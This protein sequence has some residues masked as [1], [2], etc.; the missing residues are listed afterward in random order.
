[1]V[2]GLPVHSIDTNA[3]ATWGE[4]LAVEPIDDT[5]AHTAPHRHSFTQLVLIEAGTGSHLIDF[6]RVPLAAGDLH[7]L[8]PGQVHA[9]EAGPGLAATAAMFSDGALDPIGPFPDPLRE[10]VLFGA[11]PIPTDGA[12][13]RRIRAILAAIA[14]TG[15]IE[16]GRHLTFGLLWE[17]LHALGD[18]VGTGSDFA[19][20]PLT[21]RF[22]RIAMR[23]PNAERTVSACAAELGVT[24]GHLTEHIS[25]SVG[26]T[27]GELLRTALTREA[28]RHLSGT[29]LSVAQISALLGFSTPSYFS[30]FFRR[31]AGCSPREYRH[32]PPSARPGF[33]GERRDPAPNPALDSV[34]DP[35]RDPRKGY[36]LPR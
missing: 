25:A 17:C 9:W 11:A 35:V 30:R 34:R 1:M 32:L 8:A 13:R 2:Q 20:S 24:A 16:V 10:L 23:S 19:S 29:E 21:R 5:S 36:A 31:E 14:D 4:V 28:Q 12:R 22:L 26:R 33:P 7:V 6:T 18:R 15:S 27:P 3:G